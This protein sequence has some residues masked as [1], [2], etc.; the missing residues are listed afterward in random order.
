MRAKS[1]MLIIFTG[2]MLL[3]SLQ[4]ASAKAL[5]QV[6]ILLD[7]S[8]SMDG[9]IDQAKTQLWKIVNE[10]A[11]SKK[12]GESPELQVSLYEYGNDSLPQNQDYVR[13][14]EEL[15]T[16]LDKI[17]EQLFNLTTNGGSEYCGAVIDRATREL[18]W[19]KDP[20]V[21][22]VIFIAGNEAFTQ[23]GVSYKESCK[24]AI[25][26]GIIINTIFCGG[27]DE[28]AKTGWKDGALL[29][30][31]NY[32]NIDQNLV[33]VYIEAPQDKE[34]AEI[35]K[36][37][38]DTYVPYGAEGE[39]SKERQEAQDANAG[40]AS[41]EAFIQ[42]NMAKANAQYK[43][44]EWDLV[45]AINNKEVDLEKIDKKDLPP[46]MRNMSLSERKAYIASM[47]KKRENLKNRMAQLNKDRRAY[48]DEQ[49][50]NRAE[51]NSLGNAMLDTLRTQAEKSGFDFKE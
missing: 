6:A 33:T 27:F 30:D 41:E 22:K 15:T 17:S 2:V 21:Y 29:A 11:L 9:L 31:G 42:R 25:G 40:A 14:V 47:N 48:I 8:N 23:G 20:G 45:D 18:A 16:D 50:K 35:G 32:A 51:D 3:F 37:L 5:I 49:M 26:K 36:Q 38:N 28:G 43:N 7:T 34:I 12:N 39:V 24:K 46:K 10:L 19:S 1:L 4:A 13:R 44:S